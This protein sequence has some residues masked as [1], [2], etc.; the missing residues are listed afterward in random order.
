MANRVT[1]AEVAVIIELDTD[2]TPDIT[3]FIDVANDL[4]TEN[5]LDS[6]YSDDKLEKIELWLSAHFYAIKDPRAK[7]EAAGSVNQGL[8]S[9]VDIGFDVTHYGQMA[10]R[11]DSDGNL[12]AINEDAKKGSKPLTASVTWAGTDPYTDEDE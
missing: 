1:Q 5:C 8:Q 3:A 2:T 10:M 6:D 4:V 11:I 9:K 12:A 7:S